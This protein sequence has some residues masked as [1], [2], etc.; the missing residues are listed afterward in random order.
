MGVF[1]LSMHKQMDISWELWQDWPKERVSGVSQ[2]KDYT[3]GEE[4]PK[5]SKGYK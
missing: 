5:K 1:S 4:F 3:S 2:K